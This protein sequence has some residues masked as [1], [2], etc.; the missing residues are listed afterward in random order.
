MSPAKRISKKQIKQDSFVTTALKASEY[1]QKNKNYFYMGLGVLVVIILAIYLIGYSSSQKA[2]NSENLFAEGQLA[3]AMGQ[4]EQSIISYRQ[5]V[6][7]Y[8]ATD[9]AGRACYYVAKTYYEHDQFDSA[10]VYFEKYIANYKKQPLLIVASYVGSA[11]CYEHND[12]YAK[13]GDCYFKAA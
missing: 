10:T 1:F 5:L 2:I 7:E 6:D 8:S 12:D 4:W 11:G 3:A 9:F 13:A